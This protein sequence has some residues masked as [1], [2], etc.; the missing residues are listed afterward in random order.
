VSGGLPVE[1]TAE[2]IVELDARLARSDAAAAAAAAAARA[3]GTSARQPVHTAY[4][5]ADRF[6]AHTVEEWADAAKKALATHGGDHAELADALALPVELLEAVLPGVLGKLDREPVEDLRID[7]EDGYGRHSG[8]EDGDVLAAASALAASCAA[9]SAPPFA[10]LRCKSLEGPTR[11]RAVRT[12]YGFY[13]ALAEAGGDPARLVVTHPKVSTVDQVAAITLLTAELERLLHLPS[14]SLRF[15]LQVETPRAVLGADGSSP[16]PRMIEAAHGRCS[17][18]VF[19]TYDYT[20]AIEVAPDEQRTDHPAAEHAKAVMQVA[21]AGTGVRLSDGSSNVLPVGDHA[22]VLAAWRRQARLIDRSLRSGFYQGWDLH[23]A[24]LP[25]RFLV[26]HAFFRA[27][28]PTARRRLRAYRDR[29]ASGVLDE[30]ATERALTG[31]L[32]RGLDCGALG[33]AEIGDGLA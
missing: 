27:G 2:L 4:V 28:L 18:L 15:E 30:P 1:P 14:R 26:V 19:G 32:R 20:A 8:A 29:A 12:V 10:G 25:C 7:F 3:A 22:A 13:G 24:Q 21:A 9:G 16:L 31:F 11:L 17:G 6:T 33:T 23:P 5:P